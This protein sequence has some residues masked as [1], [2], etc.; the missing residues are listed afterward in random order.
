MHTT[1]SY[2][3]ART[4][5]ADLHRQA[6]YERLA[7]AAAPVPS[8]APRPGRIRTLVSLRVR[9]GRQRRAWQVTTPAA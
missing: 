9:P 2:E 3:L 1:I 7:R 5:I 8:N 6:Q 4:R